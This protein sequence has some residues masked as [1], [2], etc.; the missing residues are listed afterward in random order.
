[1]KLVIQRVNSASV[2]ID[3]IVKASIDQGLLVL[4]GV[5]KGDVKEL[6]DELAYKTVNLRI[7]EDDKG[8]MG[9]SLKDVSGEMMIVSQFTLAG[10]CKKGLRPDFGTAM[11]PQ[12]AN[13]YYEYFIERCGMEY[14]ADKIQTGVFG[15]EMKVKLENDGP[16]TIIIEKRSEI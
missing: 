12:T 6:C 15:A 3:N 11:E 7:F 1:M 14:A 4:F 5:E 16:V 9:K 2:V 8:K 10:N 13:E